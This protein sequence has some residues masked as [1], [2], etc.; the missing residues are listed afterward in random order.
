MP[1]PSIEPKQVTSLSLDVIDIV[2]IKLSW[3][4]PNPNIIPLIFSQDFNYSVE[5]YYVRPDQTKGDIAGMGIAVLTTTFN[6]EN[7]MPNTSYRI[8]VYSMSS[9][10]METTGNLINAQTSLI[11]K[12]DNVMDGIGVDMDG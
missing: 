10:A 12:M 2:S 3:Q 9:Y 7:L 1:L 8:F 5:W 11:S 4:P 6:I